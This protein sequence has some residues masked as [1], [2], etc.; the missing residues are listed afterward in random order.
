MDQYII[1]KAKDRGYS[2]YSNWLKS[3][4][5]FSFADWY[6]PKRMG[7]GTL[8]VINDDWIKADNGFGFHP[9]QDMEIITIMFEG[10]LTHQ[11]SMGN[12]KV[13]KIDE[14]QRISAG[15][16]VL[17]FLIHVIINFQNFI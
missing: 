4:F 17:L 8:R 3:Y 16:G 9:H 11:D 13:I 14:I 10:E 7:F 15:T 2:E 1:H 6:E 12:K 5:S